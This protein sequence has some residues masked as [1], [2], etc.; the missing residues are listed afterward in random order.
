MNDYKQIEEKLG[1]KLISSRVLLDRLRILDESSRKSS[2]YQDPENLPFYYYLGKFI[3][4]KSFAQIGLDLGL[5]FSC[6]LQGNNEVEYFLGYQKL[7]DKY[8]SKRIAFSNIKDIN[9]K[10]K[11]DYYDGLIDEKFLLKIINFD[12]VLI[13]EKK[14]FDFIK[15]CLYLFWKKLNKNGI[16]L[17]NYINEEKIKNI[18]YDFCKIENLEFKIFN[19]RYKIGIIQK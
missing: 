17:V 15:N 6:Y 9:K 3:K 8:Y 12:I 16:L 1:K 18:F 5:E 14:D 7:L 10:I 13:N 4:A 11:A 19:T 2:Q